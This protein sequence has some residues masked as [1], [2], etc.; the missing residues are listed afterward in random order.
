M[1][2]FPRLAPATLFIHVA[3]A[4]LYSGWVSP[5]RNRRV[6]GYL[7]PHRRLSQL[8]TS[9]IAFQRQGIRPL[10][11][12]TCLKKTCLLLFLFNC[13]RSVTCATAETNSDK[14]NK[15]TYS[16]CQTRFNNGGGEGNRTPD[17]LRAKQMLSQLSYAPDLW[18]AWKDLNFRPHAYQACALTT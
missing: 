17:P 16:F 9:F 6:N 4:G 12:I 15:S 8:I 1:F 13:Q 7:A 3:A 2:H 14:N 18:W 11:L 10:L 5:F